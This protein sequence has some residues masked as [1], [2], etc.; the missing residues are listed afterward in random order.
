M[1]LLIKIR[2]AVLASPAKEE[3]LSRTAVA[4]LIRRE[5]KETRDGG[6]LRGGQERERV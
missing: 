2:I 6:G 4:S 3:R 5:D 1:G